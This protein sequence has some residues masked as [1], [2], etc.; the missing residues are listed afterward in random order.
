MFVENKPK[1]KGNVFQQELLDGEEIL[2]MGQPDKWRFFIS[3]D[4]FTIPFSLFWCAIIIPLFW[5]EIARGNVI[6]FFIPHVWIGF[7]MLFGRYI[8]KFLRKT[9][10]YYAVTNQRILILGRLFGRSL[11]AFSLFQAP[12]LSKYVGWGSVGTIVFESPEPKSWWNRKRTYSHS[13]AA[14]EFI[15]HITPGFYDIHEVDEVYRLIAQMA[16][17]TSYAPVEKA[18]PSYLPR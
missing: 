11:Q 3:Q 15:G 12:T 13:S 5:S 4:W 17:Q 18:K 1:R 7:Y 14:M 9:H 2:W 6:V 8:F 10:T 16:H